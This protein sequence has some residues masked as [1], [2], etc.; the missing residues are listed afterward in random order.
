ML[1]GYGWRPP[2]RDVV[3][4]NTDAGI[5]LEDRKGGGGG[6][7]R[8]HN[9]FLG[10]WSKPYDGVTDPLVA[11]SLA[12]R[13]GIIFAKLRGYPKVILETDCLELVNLWNNHHGS[14]SAVAPILHELGELVLSFSAF[15][16]QHIPRSANNVAHLCA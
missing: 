13:D 2:D 16:I 7:A 10:A 6:V 4:I 15:S 12:V 5:S 14:R 3:K 8:S 9:A 11:E 1:P